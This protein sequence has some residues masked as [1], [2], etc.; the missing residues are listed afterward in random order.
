M[1]EQ[2]QHND[3]YGK[4]GKLE[5]L[6][7]EMHETHNINRENISKTLEQAIKTN[8]RVTNLE[9]VVANQDKINSKLNGLLEANWKR[10]EEQEKRHSY[11]M[12]IL[13]VCGIVGSIILMAGGYVFTLIVK[14]ISKDSVKE[15]LSEYEINISK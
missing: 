13:K 8:G 12:G 5:G 2:R 15:V 6:M 9:H 7:Q 11:S 1:E 4:L 10:L 14:D 3:I